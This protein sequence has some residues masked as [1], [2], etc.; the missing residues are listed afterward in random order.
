MKRLVSGI[1]PTGSLTLGNYIGALRQFVKL[2][3]ELEDTE[4]FIFIADL[5]AITTP[6]E[7]QALKKSIKSIAALYMACGLDPNKVNLFVQSE[8]VE[9]AVLGYIMESTAY[10]GEMERMTQ[11]KDKKQKQ[12]EGIRTSL[13]TYPALMAADI[14]LY[15]ADIVP[16]GDDQKQHLELTR[17]LA[18]RFNNLYGDTF[19]VPEGFFPKTGARIKSLTEPDKKMDK[20]AENQKAYILLLDDLNQVKNKI[21]S[22]V[23]DSDTAIKYDLKNKAGVSNLLQIYASLTDLS[24]KDIENKYKE[25]NYK[26]F[27]ED[28]ANIVADTLK[29]IQEKYQEIINSPYLDEVLDQGRQRASEIARKK[30]FKVYKRIGLGRVK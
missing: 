3:D 4:F 20:S 25:S 19:V 21:R 17:N 30:M 18:Q 27:K 29:P 16:I 6:Q 9:H 26:K 23:T 22:A 28:L 1:K 13:L 15:D 11:Y 24:I 2:Q 8:V 12:T 14:L 5:H 10:V 7:K